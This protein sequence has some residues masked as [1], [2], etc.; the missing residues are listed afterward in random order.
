MMGIEP[1]LPDFFSGALPLSYMWCVVYSPNTGHIQ[2]KLGFLPT[3]IAPALPES[4]FR[5]A[6]ITLWRFTN[7]I[8]FSRLYGLYSTVHSVLLTRSPMP[9]RTVLLSHAPL[10]QS[11]H[12]WA[13]VIPSDTAFAVRGNRGSRTL[14]RQHYH[15]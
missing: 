1:T 12:T 14:L 8:R 7:T 4:A 9:Y 15:Y 10:L 6:S 2:I 3:G 5:R 13:L 11:V